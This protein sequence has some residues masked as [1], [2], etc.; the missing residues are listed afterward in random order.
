MRVND[1]TTSLIK[2]CASYDFA[3]IVWNQCAL[4]AFAIGM[5][6][7]VQWSQNEQRSGLPAV[8]RATEM[9][10]PR[11]TAEY[12]RRVAAEIDAL[13][14]KSAEPEL[15]RELQNLAERFRRMAERREQERGDG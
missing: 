8:S 10:D 2:R 5:V 1:A 7:L 3:K 6:W 15:R 13:A 14:A 11:P 4:R 9:S 12:Y